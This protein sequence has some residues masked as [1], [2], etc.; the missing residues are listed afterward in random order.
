MA[1][2]VIWDYSI[3]ILKYLVNF[4]N[5]CIMFEICDFFLAGRSNCP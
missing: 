2:S 5:L 3:V 4:F 1:Q